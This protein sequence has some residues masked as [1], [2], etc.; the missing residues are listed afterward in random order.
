MLPR[1]IAAT[2]PAGVFLTCGAWHTMTQ[3]ARRG[4]ETAISLHSDHLPTRFQ[5]LL[6]TDARAIYSAFQIA[7]AQDPAHRPSC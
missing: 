6:R 1:P 4:S 7:Q 3:G 2:L 5:P